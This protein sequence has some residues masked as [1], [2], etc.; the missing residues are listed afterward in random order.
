MSIPALNMTDIPATAAVRYIAMAAPTSLSDGMSSRRGGAVPRQSAGVGHHRRRKDSRHCL[1]ST[2]TAPT[3]R[4]GT[5]LRSH[6]Q[7]RPRAAP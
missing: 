3:T 5:G 4:S 7:Y 1:A 2:S 6:P